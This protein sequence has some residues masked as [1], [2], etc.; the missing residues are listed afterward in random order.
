VVEG[1]GIPTLQAAG[2][3][4]RLACALVREGY[5]AAVFSSDY[6]CLVHGAHTMIT[7]RK[8]TYGRKNG[9]LQIMVEVVSLAKVLKAMNLEFKRFVE[10]CIASGCDYNTNIPQIGISKVLGLMNQHG[11]LLKIAKK[12]NL[13]RDDDELALLNY[14]VA[15]KLF[16]SRCVA[17]LVQGEPGEYYEETP[18]E[19]D[20]PIEDFPFHF[21]INPNRLGICRGLLRKYHLEGHIATYAHKY[22]GLTT[23]TPKRPRRT[24]CYMPVKIACLPAFIPPKPTSSDKKSKS[25]Q[26]QRQKIVDVAEVGIPVESQE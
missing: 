7:G 15:S 2:E 17:E 5:C 25:Q 9:K 16:R 13:R 22:Q 20:P 1:L 11:S 12:W 10:V 14:P 8:A 3:A 26:P 21:K 6:D 19:D 18:E 24:Y 23:P 4:E